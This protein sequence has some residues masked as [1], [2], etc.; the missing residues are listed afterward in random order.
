MTHIASWDRIVGF[1]CALTFASTVAVAG[2]YVCGIKC[3]WTGDA[4]VASSEVRICEQ[5]HRNANEGEPGQTSHYETE[6]LQQCWTM[7]SGDPNDWFQGPCDEDPGGFW[8]PIGQ[9][10]LESGQ[11]CWSKLDYEEDGD[12]VDGLVMIKTCYGIG[13]I[14]PTQIE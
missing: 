3:S 1:S 9:C 5:P 13:C 10:G 11:C 8:N 12:P 14:G 6:T 2:C 7:S 4:C